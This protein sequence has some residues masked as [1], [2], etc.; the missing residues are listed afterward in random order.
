MIYHYLP[1]ELA[2]LGVIRK[3]DGLNLL[4]VAEQMQLAKEREDLASTAPAEA[5][6]LSEQW[7]SAYQ[8]NQW[9]RIAH[10][11]TEQH[12]TVYALAEDVRAVRYEEQRQQ[13]LA[14]EKMHAERSGTAAPELL[15]HRVY[16]ITAH[17]AAA[18]APNGPALVLHLMADS[19]SDAATR[20]W[21]FHGRPGGIYRQGAYRIT[22]IEQVLPEPGE[23]F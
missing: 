20:A 17:S 14:D 9:R 1:H 3:A 6:H 13:Q 2:R 22:A 15:R 4:Q 10:T 8:H 21:T 18:H 12:A 19:L 5:H 23:L 16:R 7:I 11:M